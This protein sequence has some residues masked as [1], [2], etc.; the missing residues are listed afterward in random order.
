M[1]GNSR[2]PSGGVVAASG[3]KFGAVV[4]RKDLDAATQKLF[5]T[6]FFRSVN[7]R[8]QPKP[9]DRGTGYVVTLQVGEEKAE[10]PVHLDIPGVDEA[11]LWAALRSADVLIDKMMPDT[12]QS[13]AYYIRA[14]EV[15]LE[16][17]NRREPI[18]MKT[19][20]DFT[21]LVSG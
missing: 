16:Q 10:T 17:S 7:Y 3:L 2:L 21:P 20:V 18:T 6:G 5:E 12:E 1:E 19:E 9:G 15:A 14:I 13:A 4:T 11:Q 8:Y